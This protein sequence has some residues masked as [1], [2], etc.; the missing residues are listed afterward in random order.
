MQ[1]QPLTKSQRASTYW[2]KHSPYKELSHVQLTYKRKTKSKSPKKTLNR[3]RSIIDFGYNFL[4]EVCRGGSRF[5][6][7]DRSSVEINTVETWLTET[8]LCV[9]KYNTVDRRSFLH[10][11]RKVRNFQEIDFIEKIVKAHLYE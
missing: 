3:S 7:I 6:N 11:S 10:L 1:G 9:E 8:N 4:F 2:E 5:I